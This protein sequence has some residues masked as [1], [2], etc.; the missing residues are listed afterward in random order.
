MYSPVSV[1]VPVLKVGEPVP[2]GA[3]NDVESEALSDVRELAATDVDSDVRAELL[4]KN[5]AELAAED[6]TDDATEVAEAKED[7]GNSL[8]TLADEDAAEVIADDSELT[9]AAEDGAEITEVT[10]EETGGMEATTLDTALE[11]LASSLEGAAL[12]KVASWMRP[13]A[14]RRPVESFMVSDVGV[15]RGFSAPPLSSYTNQKSYTCPARAQKQMENGATSKEP[16]RRSS[17]EQCHQPLTVEPEKAT[18][19]RGRVLYRRITC[20][21]VLCWF[22]HLVFCLRGSMGL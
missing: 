20:S 10:A 13:S 11:M 17:R 9:L 14:T 5:D 21:P 12:A 19:G 6:A 15:K 8:L 3:T 16:V 1:P 2:V 22:S 4:V 7:E 18:N